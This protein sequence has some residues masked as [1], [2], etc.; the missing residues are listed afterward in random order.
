MGGGGCAWVVWE[1][2]KHYLYI[3]MYVCMYMG[4]GGKA[5]KEGCGWACVRSVGRSSSS[6]SYPLPTISIHPPVGSTPTPTR[7]NKDTLTHI[8]IYTHTINTLTTPTPPPIHSLTKVIPPKK[9]Q[10]LNTLVGSREAVQRA[11]EWVVAHRHGAV[12]ALKLMRRAVHRMVG[13]QTTQAQ[14]AQVNLVGVGRGEWRVRE[15]GCG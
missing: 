11:R 7:Q 8:Y 10:I 2:A 13:A 15:V 12:H 3:Y 14:A 9:K 5:G 6:S 1:Q 4:L